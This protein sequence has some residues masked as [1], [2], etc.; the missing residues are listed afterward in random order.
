M[1]DAQGR[2]QKEIHYCI[3]TEA[4]QGNRAG[5]NNIILAQNDYW[6]VEH[7]LVFIK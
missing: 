4:I 7:T 3:Y 5:L 6:S 2:I 1:G